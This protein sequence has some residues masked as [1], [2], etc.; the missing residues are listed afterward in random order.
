MAVLAAPYLV[1]GWVPVILLALAGTSLPI[2]YALI[3]IM[4]AIINS[5]IPAGDVLGIVLLVTQ[6]P[7]SA[8]V[9][10]KGWKSYWIPGTQCGA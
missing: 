8:C 4:T 7:A 2:E 3:L 9:K 1:L 6:I 10:N 5:A